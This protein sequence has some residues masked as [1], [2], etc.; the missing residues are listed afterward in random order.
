MTVD[1]AFSA[2]Y[3]TRMLQLIL[4]HDGKALLTQPIDAEKITI[5]RSQDNTLQLVD[6]A[7]SRIHCYI[8][9]KKGTPIITDLSRNGTYLNGTP[10]STSALNPGDTIGIGPWTA[11]VI[12]APTSSTD[13]TVIEQHAP[14]RVLAY[15]DASHTISTEHLAITAVSPDQHPLKKSFHQHEITFGSAAESDIAIADEY[16]SRQHCKLVARSDALM[17][18]DCGSTNGTLLD[19]VRVEKVSLP[20]QGSFTIGKTVVRYSRERVSERVTPST[21]PH[22]GAMLGKSRAM[23]EVFSLIRRVAPTN[24]PICIFGESGTGKELAARELHRLSGRRAGPFIALNCGA[25]PSTMIES[26]LFGHERGAFTGA[27]ERQT[28]VFEQ[29]HGGTLFLD[30]IG[31]MELGLQT[32]LLRVLEDG[33]LRR[34]GGKDEIKVDVRLVVATNR[35]LRAC[36][37]EGTFREDLFYRI[38]VVPVQLPPLRERTEDIALLAARLLEERA[39]DNR[40]ITL[41]GDALAKLTAYE[42]PGNVRELRNTLLR[43]MIVTRG[44]CIEAADLQLIGAPRATSDIEHIDTRERDAIVDALRRAEGNQTKA[45]KYLG[46]ARSTMSFKIGRYGI[47]PKKL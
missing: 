6:P 34:L 38:Y 4:M 44:T 36:V 23:R 8:E 29:A 31:E 41:G 45:C 16:V 32:R 7:I 30:E 5:G 20:P 2:D 21:E 43:A 11:K 46:I 27:V 19:G 33:M 35:D 47:D 17:L 9:H 14:T 18:I 39:P 24:V 25:I 1:S 40:V 37:R 12:A 15:D 10:I 42:W 26:M 3:E 13:V 28:G 22:L